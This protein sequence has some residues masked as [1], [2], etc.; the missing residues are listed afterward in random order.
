MCWVLTNFPVLILSSSSYKYDEE[1]YSNNDQNDHH[2]WHDNTCAKQQYDVVI[3]E[4][5]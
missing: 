2:N 4:L 3:S 5:I 1:H